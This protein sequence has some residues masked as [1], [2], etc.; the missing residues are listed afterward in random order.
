L[1]NISV[2]ELGASYIKTPK[3]ISKILGWNNY[4]KI[5]FSWVLYFY[6][7][8]VNKNTKFIKILRWNNYLKNIFFWV[9]YFYYKIKNK[10]TKFI[11]DKL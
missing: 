9:L 2:E 1:Y 11:N 8:N 6:Y 10:N 4:L 5:F 3:E 7:K